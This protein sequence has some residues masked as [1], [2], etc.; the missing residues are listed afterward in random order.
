MM[1]LLPST[2]I[3]AFRK[4]CSAFTGACFPSMLEI[5][6]NKIILGNEVVLRT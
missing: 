4:Y 3:E 6:I 2:S 5:T 1:R